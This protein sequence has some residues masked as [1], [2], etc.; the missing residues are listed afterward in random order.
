MRYNNIIKLSRCRRSDESLFNL[1][2]FDNIPNL[3]KT[4]FNKMKLK[5][6]FVG[7]MKKENQ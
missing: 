3:E 7:P 2:Q 1:V 4:N 6:I 5:L